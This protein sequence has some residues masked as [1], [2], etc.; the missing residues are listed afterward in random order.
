MEFE[1]L[2]AQLVNMMG[3]EGVHRGTGGAGPDIVAINPRPFV[4]GK[5][6][7]EA[8]RYRGAVSVSEVR[9]LYGTVLDEGA[10]R[11]Y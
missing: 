11:A 2:I 4:G 5:V 7:I 3:F 6:V 8:K 1:S 9:A 10:S